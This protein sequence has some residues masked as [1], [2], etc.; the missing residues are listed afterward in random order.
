MEDL[1]VEDFKRTGEVLFE[2]DQPVVAMWKNGERIFVRLEDGRELDITSI[3][4][5]TRH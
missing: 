3:A 5:K 1:S 4:S 2:F